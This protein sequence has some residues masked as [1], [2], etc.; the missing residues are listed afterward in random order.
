MASVSINI[1][2]FT[3]KKVSLEKGKNKLFVAQ[4]FLALDLKFAWVA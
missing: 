1:V 3:N 4:R 2:D